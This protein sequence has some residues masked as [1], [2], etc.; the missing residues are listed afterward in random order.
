MSDY[1]PLYV[2]LLIA[3]L[4]I[5]INIW[6]GLQDITNVMIIFWI[7]KQFTQNLST[8]FT[9]IIFL[10]CSIKN[11]QL[12]SSNSS[13]ILQC[14][15]ISREITYSEN[16]TAV[17]YSTTYTKGPYIKFSRTQGGF[18]WK[19]HGVPKFRILIHFLIDYDCRNV[20][21]VLKNVRAKPFAL[22]KA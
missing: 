20:L 22:W 1:F 8:W 21:I 19:N 7:F 14:L 16:K 4:V 6:I 10:I 13:S 18:L 11:Y 15:V 3:I 9:S 2:Y 12:F 5:G 17:F